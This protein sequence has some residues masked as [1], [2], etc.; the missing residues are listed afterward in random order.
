LAREHLARRLRLWEFS[1]SLQDFGARAIETS[2]V[3][4]SLNQGQL[5]AWRFYLSSDKRRQDRFM[6]ALR[7][8][9]LPV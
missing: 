1:F 8:A 9:D 4:P 2:R 7:E 3:I 6:D 5:M